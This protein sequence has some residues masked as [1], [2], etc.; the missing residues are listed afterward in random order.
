MQRTDDKP[1]DACGDAIRRQHRACTLEYSLPLRARLLELA[2][3]TSDVTEALA[4]REALYE[5]A[6]KLKSAPRLQEWLYWLC[7]DALTP[8]NYTYARRQIL[9]IAG[10]I[11]D[12]LRMSC[13]C[14]D[15]KLNKK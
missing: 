11:D 8:E 7:S 9:I 15:C 6:D 13:T 4:T 14:P 12:I 5:E 2:D 1:L 10:S 3:K